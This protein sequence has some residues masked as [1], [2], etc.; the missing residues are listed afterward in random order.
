MGIAELPQK[1]KIEIFLRVYVAENIQRWSFTNLN[2]PLWGEAKS[3][4]ILS[5]NTNSTLKANKLMDRRLW[6]FRIWQY[7]ESSTFLSVKVNS[8]FYN[9]SIN[10]NAEFLNAEFLHAD[11]R[12]SSLQV[13]FCEF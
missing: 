9:I 3:L 10:N 5:L 7:P 1:K 6:A 8:L 13:T 2:L 4:R 12:I 11:S